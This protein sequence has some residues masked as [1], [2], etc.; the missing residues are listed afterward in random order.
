MLTER[1]A[2]A[3]DDTTWLADA[4]QVEEEVWV[5]AKLAVVVDESDP[6]N[7]PD[8]DR[9]WD[10]VPETV[11]EGERDTVTELHEGDKLADVVGEND[12]LGASERL[13]V[14]EELG[15]LELLRLPEALV[16]ERVEV[17]A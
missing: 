11:P 4:E 8:G 10:S 16:T 2:V 9:D 5:G 15:E 7:E 14:T 1:D 6:D 17:G 3:L 12:K 13:L